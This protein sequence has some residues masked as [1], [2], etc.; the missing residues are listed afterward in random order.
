MALI[1]G[2]IEIS[3]LF[4]ISF[5]LLLLFFFFFMQ[6]YCIYIYTYIHTYILI[7]HIFS[8][9]NKQLAAKTVLVSENAPCNFL[10]VVQR[11]LCV[12]VA[13]PI[14]LISV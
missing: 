8:L 3:I 1:I 12:S 5:L 2:I 7:Q 10:Y 9:C 4:L 14:L 6:R 13:L 11:Y